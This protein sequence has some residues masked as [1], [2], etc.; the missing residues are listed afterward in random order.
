MSVLAIV[1]APVLAKAA[2][3]DP[4]VEVPPAAIVT[5]VGSSSHSR[6]RMVLF[7]VP[8]KVPDVSTRL[9]IKVELLTV[10]R[11]ANAPDE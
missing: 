4:P 7:S 3:K 10:V 2:V 5:L 6:A 1:M 11:P 8:S 9:E